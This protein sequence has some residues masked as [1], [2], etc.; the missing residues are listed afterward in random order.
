[1]TLIELLFALTLIGI[2]SLLVVPAAA[3]GKSA[4]DGA[5]CVANLRSIGL[6]TLSF[7]AENE[8]Q[9]PP[10]RTWDTDILPYTDLPLTRSSALFRCPADRRPHSAST[11]TRSYTASGMDP[12]RP[13]KGVFSTRGQT[14][15]RKLTQ[16][17]FPATT[18]IYFECF[19]DGQGNALPNRVG[20]PEF[21][22]T[23]GFESHR[24]TPK[25][26][27]GE[28]YHGTKMAFVFADGH[29]SLLSPLAAFA[30]S[31]NVWRVSPDSNAPAR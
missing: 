28:F 24:D 9:L 6:A 26:K 2:L 20:R 16:L 21:S 25:L 12:A 5:R 10:G 4:A 18:A 19:T 13:D 17:M 29:A 8:G 11:N 15:S 3:A 27:S 22:W 30:D 31:K 1:M 14:V 23:Y 7:A